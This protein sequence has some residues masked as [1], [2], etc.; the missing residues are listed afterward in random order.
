MQVLGSVGRPPTLRRHLA[1]A[2]QHEAVQAVARAVRRARTD[3][4]DSHRPIGSFL[5]VGP[6]GVGKT[7]VARALA[8][9]LFGNEEAM[10]KLDMSEFMESHNVSRLTG[11]PPGYVGFDQAGQLTEAVRRHPYS[12]VLF[13]EIE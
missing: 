13:D 8:E 10:L 12:V 1:V 7:E 5:F 11:S 4:R 2:Q 6:T 3:L 9:T